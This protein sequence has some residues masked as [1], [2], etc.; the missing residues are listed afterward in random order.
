[1]I[2]LIQKQNAIDLT[3]VTLK[4]EDGFSPV[5]E[6]EEIEGGHQITITDANGT[7]SFTVMDGEDIE[8]EN[9]YTKQ[10]TDAAIEAAQP[11]L[12]GYAL[13]S[14][15]VGRAGTGLRSAI[16]NGNTNKA[17]GDY[18][19][20]E[21]KGTTSAGT[22]THTEGI[23][24]FTRAMA[25]HVHGTYNE[26]DGAGS[27]Q[28]KGKYV[29]IV[30][31]GE[32]ENN[33]SNAHTLDWDGNAWFKGKVYVG[34]TSMDNATALDLSKYYTKD[35]TYSK[36]E[37]DEAIAAIEIPEGEGFKHI[38]VNSYEELDELE[39]GLYWI[40]EVIELPYFGAYSGPL[41]KGDGVLDFLGC[42]FYMYY[43][44][45]ITDGTFYEYVTYDVMEE[46]YTKEETAKEI[47]DAIAAIEI[48]D[49]TP[50]ATT[51]V[52]GKVKPDGSTITI[53]ADGVIS[54]VGGS[55]GGDSVKEVHVG[56]TEP[57]DSNVRIWINPNDTPENIYATQAY[58]DAAIA[59]IT[60]GEEVSY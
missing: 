42:G 17:S 39:K 46:Y 8:F 47:E 51:E 27:P 54:A 30:G 33:R 11:D 38:T 25:Q 43:G 18:A 34:G 14:E 59:A 1:M 58:V 5:I 26:L 60:N 6:V 22:A 37:V 36:A 32:D 4:G 44:S 20:A 19:L 45:D 28:W 48:P 9:Y 10:E 15:I 12:T 50:V 23:G 35:E 21:G 29:T 2:K 56:T 57:T 13:K 52:A 7:Q 49:N 31:N 53:T 3:N 16:L 24:T 55:S 40:D 41:I